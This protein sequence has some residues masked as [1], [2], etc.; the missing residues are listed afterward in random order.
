M[1][2]GCNISRVW[3]EPTK[4]RV[5]SRQ[6][7]IYCTLNTYN[8][9]Q[10]CWDTLERMRTL[11][12][13]TSYHNQFFPSPPYQCCFATKIPLMKPQFFQTTLNEGRG[14]GKPFCNIVSVSIRGNWEVRALIAFVSTSLVQD[15]STIN[16][17]SEWTDWDI[18]WIGWDANILP[19]FEM[20]RVI[21]AVCEQ[22]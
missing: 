12:L 21:I 10:N 15:C 3:K 14:E 13:K 4:A 19:S 20:N 6:M 9:G 2:A 8:L 5:K 17:W 1:H 11:T 16:T 22:F 7:P 18:V